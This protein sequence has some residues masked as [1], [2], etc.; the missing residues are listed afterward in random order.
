MITYTVYAI[1]I[2]ISLI[3]YLIGKKRGHNNLLQKINEGTGRVG[4][5]K[6][7]Y[8]DSDYNR[9]CYYIEVKEVASAGK[10]IKVNVID[11]KAE[12]GCRYSKTRLLND[13]IEWVPSEDI[14]W[15]DDNSQRLRD[16]KLTEILGENK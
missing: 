12:K 14:I 15:Y 1:L 5:I 9:H 3:T 8:K 2:V 11:V 10:L 7:E 13:F 6:A 4:I 16:N